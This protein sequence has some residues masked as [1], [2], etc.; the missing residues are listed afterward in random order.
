[1]FWCECVC[2]CLCEGYVCDG[3]TDGEVW[4]TTETVTSYWSWCGWFEPLPQ[5]CQARVVIYTPGGGRC[6]CVCVC[7]CVCVRI[8][9][10]D[11]CTC[12]QEGKMSVC[13]C[14]YEY[15]ISLSMQKIQ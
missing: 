10:I 4:K 13:V 8:V 3:E 11:T 1:M 12:M 9:L 14:V 6:A 7:V 5:L 15:I 2:V